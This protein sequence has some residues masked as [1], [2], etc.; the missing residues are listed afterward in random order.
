MSFE[1]PKQ[2][3]KEDEV[4]NLNTL[5]QDKYLQDKIQDAENISDVLVA[6]SNVKGIQGSDK[7]WSSQEIEEQILEKMWHSPTLGGHITR[8]FG[9]RN[10]VN[11]LLESHEPL[12][13]YGKNIEQ[14]VSFVIDYAIDINDLL[15]QLRSIGGLVKNEKGKFTNYTYNEIKKGIEYAIQH[16]NEPDKERYRYLTRSYGLREKT[17]ELVTK[18]EDKKYSK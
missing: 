8:N 18:L 3:S 16:K 15:G 12:V 9:L 7:F 13:I 5:E 6:L 14:Y 4:E 10:K 2:P 1:S 17:K 11:N